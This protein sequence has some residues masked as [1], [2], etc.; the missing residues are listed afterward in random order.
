MIEMF[1]CM[2]EPQMLIEEWQENFTEKDLTKR[3]GQ[4]VLSGQ[5]FKGC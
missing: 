2:Q 5:R 3:V 4:C 1:Y